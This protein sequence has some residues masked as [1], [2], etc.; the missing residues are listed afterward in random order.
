[1]MLT[2]A[3]IT[4]SHPAFITAD[5]TR[6]CGQRSSSL[7][8]CLSMY[9]R[10]R[11]F[12][13][14]TCKWF[15]SGHPP[16]GASSP[17]LDAHNIKCHEMM[18][19]DAWGEAAKLNLIASHE[20]R[21]ADSVCGEIWST[22]TRPSRGSQSAPVTRSRL[23][24]AIRVAGG[25]VHGTVWILLR[26]VGVRV[27]REGGRLRAPSTVQLFICKMTSPLVD[28]LELLSRV[29]SETCLEG[30]WTSTTDGESLVAVTACC[31]FWP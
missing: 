6:I 22:P 25:S 3:A 18:D 10:C 24:R 30:G 31:S 26:H 20:V 16:K 29:D 17:H 12:A 19:G 8:S 14:I 13:A 15:V 7:L 28:I 23:S 21:K 5:S 11:T 2:T 9:S 27:P 1:M 4:T